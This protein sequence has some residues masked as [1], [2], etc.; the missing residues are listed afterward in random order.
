M[1]GGPEENRVSY[2]QRSNIPAFLQGVQR[3]C[4]IEYPI[5]KVTRIL[6]AAVLN[7][8]LSHC[9]P[10]QCYRSGQPLLRLCHHC[11]RYLMAGTRRS[12]YL[13]TTRSTRT[14]IETPNPPLPHGIRTRYKITQNLRHES[15]S[16]IIPRQCG[17]DP[18]GL[19]FIAAII[20]IR[21]Q[22]Q[23]PACISEG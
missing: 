19:S 18:Y 10:V 22:R 4:F 15:P 16:S 3:R 23:M 13:A 9:R 12:R 21:S 8:S 17:H 11:I 14:G 5:C 7:F 1:I 2:K 6:S 20:H